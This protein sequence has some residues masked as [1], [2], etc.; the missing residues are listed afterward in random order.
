ML[1]IKIE[2]ISHRDQ[3]YDTIGDWQIDHDNNAII[4]RVSDMKD[5][6]KEAL[7][8]VHELIE[9]IL[10][11]A[12]G[13]TEHKV[14]NFDFNFKGDGEPGDDPD[15]PYCKEHFTATNF[16]RLLA[17]ELEID[18]TDYELTID[19]LPKWRKHK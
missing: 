19:S 17:H 1:K 6:K 13:I 10:C 4:I 11:E 5:W 7:V 8:A 14:D 9:V 2:T 18:W 3:R 15:A 12:R 16:E